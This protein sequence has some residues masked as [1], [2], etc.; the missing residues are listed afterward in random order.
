MAA[1]V[2]SLSSYHRLLFPRTSRYDLRAMRDVIG[3]DLQSVKLH[4][5][6]TNPHE[7]SHSCTQ[8]KQC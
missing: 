4:V 5:L 6:I 7:G 2:P 8:L 3:A 1:D